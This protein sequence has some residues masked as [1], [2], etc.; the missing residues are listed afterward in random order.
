MKRIFSR[1]IIFDFH[2]SIGF[3][4]PYVYIAAQAE[5]LGLSKNDGSYLLAVIGG[6]NTIGRIVLGY[7]SDKPYVNRLYVYNACLTLCGICKFF[8][9]ILVIG[10]LG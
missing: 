10:L 1:M 9:N 5:F 2:F 7:L 6:A 3:N 4:I 8:P